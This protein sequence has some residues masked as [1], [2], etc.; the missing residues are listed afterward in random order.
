MC[1]ECHLPLRAEAWALRGLSPTPSG[2]LPKLLSSMAE[3]SAY[4]L[5]RAENIARNQAKL[6]ALSLAKM[7]REF[8]ELAE[9]ERQSRGRKQLTDEEKAEVRLHGAGRARA[10]G[11]GAAEARRRVCFVGRALARRSRRCS[12][13]VGAA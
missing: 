4:E 7:G 1:H 2:P 11:A 12:P 13:R 8:S 10:R 6:R 3:L 5:K 9:T